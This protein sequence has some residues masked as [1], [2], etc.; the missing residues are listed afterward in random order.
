MRNAIRLITL[1]SILSCGI[2][3]SAQAQG[4]AVCEPER[5]VLPGEFVVPESITYDPNTNRFYVGSAA[6][7]AIFTGIVGDAESVEV[8]SP[9]GQMDG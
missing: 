3:V 6:T 7:S 9:A 1:F 5:Y 2:S 4:T 8:F